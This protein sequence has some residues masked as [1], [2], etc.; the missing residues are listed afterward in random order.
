MANSS[1]ENANS[2][3]D[4]NKEQS[5]GNEPQVSTRNKRGAAKNAGRLPVERKNSRQAKAKAAEA[6]AKAS[7]DGDRGSEDK[8]EQSGTGKDTDPKDAGA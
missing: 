3:A 5:T 8:T 1:A 2:A 7:E 6:A 4:P